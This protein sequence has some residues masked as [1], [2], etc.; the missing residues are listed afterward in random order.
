MGNTFKRSLQDRVYNTGR[1]REHT[2]N[3]GSN[4]PA[5]YQDFKL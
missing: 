3:L 2:S 4:R 1:Q 5:L